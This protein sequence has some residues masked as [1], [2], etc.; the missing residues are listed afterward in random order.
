MIEKLTKKQEEMLQEYARAGI[1][2]GLATGAEMD[3]KKVRELTDAHRVMREVP[4]AKNFLVFD[5]P[6]A[7]IKEI[8]DIDPSNALYGQHDINW[9]MYLMYY[10][11]ELGF[12]K[13]TEQIVHLFELAKQVHWMW[14]SSDT[15]VV[16]RRPV[17]IHM[18]PKPHT[19]VENFRVLHNYD[20]HALKYADGTGIYM[21]N[22]VEIPDNYSWAVTTPAEEL[23]VTEVLSIRN[24]EVRTEVLKKIGVERAFDALDKTLLNEYTCPL[25]NDYWLYDIQFGNNVRKY[26]RMYCPSKK[27]L[28]IEAVPPQVENCE[29][30]L[31][32][33]E[34]EEPITKPYIPPE[35]RT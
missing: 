34:Y 1:E 15:T 17:E 4:K 19:T 18:Q 30:A 33:R 24:T 23:D 13:E 11:V 22:G 7:A 25:G 28:A 9:L 6:F 3:E 8:P 2:I 20:D 10:R 16:T 14:M 21:F 32:W 27:E 31:N 5:S 29:Q 12:T 26:L 35:M